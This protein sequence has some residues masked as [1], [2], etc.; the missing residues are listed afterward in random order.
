[1]GKVRGRSYTKV[2]SDRTKVTKAQWEVSL[3]PM[4]C[5]F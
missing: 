2:H 1:M 4:S 5:V 3:I